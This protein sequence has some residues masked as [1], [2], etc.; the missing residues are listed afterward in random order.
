M[1][2]ISKYITLEKAVR[3]TT[4]IEKGIKNQPGARELK[5]MKTL[6]EKVHTPATE[7]FGFPIPFSSFYRSPSLN[8]I[9]GGAKNS[10]H[11]SGEA[12]DLDMDMIEKGFD[13]KDLFLWIQEN[14]EFDQ[15]IWEFGN[16]TKPDWVHVSY[17]DPEIRANRKQVLQAIRKNGAVQYIPFTLKAA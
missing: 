9:I 13:N 12:I 4:A 17:V 7:H 8:R 6:A 11:V 1:E 16:A 3:S 2:A 10:Q 14:L 5:S 15:L